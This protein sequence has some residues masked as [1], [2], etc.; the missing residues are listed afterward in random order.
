MQVERY[1]EGMLQSADFGTVFSCEG[2]KACG[3]GI[4]ALILNSGKVAPT[5]FADSLFGNLMRVIVA[6][7]GTT[8]ALLHIYEGRDR[9]AVY[10]AVMD[11][12]S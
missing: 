6:Q 1:Y 12:V 9:R 4:G 2:E 10:E 5:G 7:R 3:S 8:W 11:G